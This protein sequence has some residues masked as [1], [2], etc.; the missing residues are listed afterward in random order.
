METDRYLISKTQRLGS[1]WDLAS[2]HMSSFRLRK[3]NKT[4]KTHKNLNKQQW[5]NKDSHQSNTRI[6]P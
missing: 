2:G 4:E 1:I 5:K 3:Q 6:H